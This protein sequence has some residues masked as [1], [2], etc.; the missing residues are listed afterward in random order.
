VAARICPV[1]LSLSA[2]WSMRFSLGARVISR[3]CS[4][5]SWAASILLVTRA[6]A[7]ANRRAGI[8]ATVVMMRQMAATASPAGGDTVRMFDAT[9]PMV[10]ARMAMSTETMRKTAQSVRW[11]ASAIA[12]SAR[13]KLTV[14]HSPSS[15]A[16][17]G[18]GD[19][20]RSPQTVPGVPESFAKACQMKAAMTPQTAHTGP[21]ANTRGQ[22]FRTKEVGGCLRFAPWGSSACCARAALLPAGGLSS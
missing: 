2:K 7:T 19:D 17:A 13:L 14:A 4:R 6:R 1:G 12:P 10:M 3:D 20:V 21:T 16:M 11:K 8:S 9:T 15:R 22:G 5:A 18:S